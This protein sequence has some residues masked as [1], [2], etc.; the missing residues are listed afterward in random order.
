MHTMSWKVTTIKCSLHRCKSGRCRTHC[1]GV[2]YAYLYMLS[3]FCC[4]ELPELLA[5]NR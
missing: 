1:R 2:P 3:I 5:G 4:I